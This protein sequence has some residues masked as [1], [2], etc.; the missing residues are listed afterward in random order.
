MFFAYSMYMSIYKYAQVMNAKMCMNLLRSE[1]VKV[2]FVF[3]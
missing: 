1:N 3:T 2:I